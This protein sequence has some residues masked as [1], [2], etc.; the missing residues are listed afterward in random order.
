MVVFTKRRKSGRERSLVEKVHSPFVLVK[1]ACPMR[2]QAEINLSINIY[3]CHCTEKN[4]DGYHLTDKGILSRKW[5]WGWGK[6]RRR[7]KKLLLLLTSFRTEM[8]WT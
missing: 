7:E 5:N 1:L 2:Q 8:V 6:G 3:I 4:L